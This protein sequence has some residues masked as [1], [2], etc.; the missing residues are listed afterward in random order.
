MRNSISARPVAGTE[1][2][3]WSLPYRPALWLSQRRCAHDRNAGA[4]IDAA[5]GQEGKA[6]T[7]SAHHDSAGSKLLTSIANQHNFAVPM[8]ERLK[9][10]KMA[11]YFFIIV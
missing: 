7:R 6:D 1:A 8:V 9:H 11:F 5:H 10:S 3:A 4:I 2:R